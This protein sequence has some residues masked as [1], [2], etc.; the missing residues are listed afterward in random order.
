MAYGREASGGNK[1]WQAS[2]EVADPWSGDGVRV[3][4]YGGRGARRSHDA[5][6]GRGAAAVPR[7]ESDARKVKT[8][9][10][11]ER[12]VAVRLGRSCLWATRRWD[13]RKRKPRE[14]E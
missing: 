12:T 14:R 1:A 4:I 11:E 5:R 3:P 10:Q 9:C 13:E 2:S 8:G 6:Y 7:T